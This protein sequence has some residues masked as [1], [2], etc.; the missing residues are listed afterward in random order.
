MRQKLFLFSSLAFLLVALI[1]TFLAFKS[2]DA[3]RIVNFGAAVVFATNS[4]LQ[5]MNFRR[6]RSA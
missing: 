3:K 4:I 6:Q 1:F 5:F 2:H